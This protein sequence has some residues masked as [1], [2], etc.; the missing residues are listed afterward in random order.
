M[1]F[2]ELEDTH[3]LYAVIAHSILIYI[4]KMNIY[5]KNMIYTAVCLTQSLYLCII[6]RLIDCFG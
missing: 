6:K 5:I 3:F 1:P 2:V 4:K